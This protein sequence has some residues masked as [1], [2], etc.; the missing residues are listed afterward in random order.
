MPSVAGT[1]DPVRRSSGD[2]GWFKKFSSAAFYWLINHLT[3]TPIRSGVADFCLLSR[4]AHQAL[5]SMPERHRFLRGMVSWMGFTRT[6]I[7]YQAAE[8]GAGRSSYNLPKMIGLA[9]DA[10]FSFSTTPIRLA[11][12]LGVA[13]IMLGAGYFFYAFIKAMWFDGVVDGW[14]STICIVLIL[15]GA[16][17][18]FIG[19]I[20]AYVA[21]VFEQVKGRPLYFFKQTPP[22]TGSGRQRLRDAGG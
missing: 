15:G 10:A 20:G 6:F 11:T 21:R 17:L 7:D 22:S 16:N 12:R 5:L 9:M 13:I 2:V 18:A 8:R 3:N 19:L 14:T 1:E 4:R